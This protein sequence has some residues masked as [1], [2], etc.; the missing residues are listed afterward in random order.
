MLTKEESKF[1]LTIPSSTD[2]RNLQGVNNQNI[3]II[4]DLLNVNFTIRNGELIFNGSKNNF[5]K[6][7]IIIN[8]IIELLNSDY[9]PKKSD[10]RYIIQMVNHGEKPHLHKLLNKKVVITAKKKVITPKT[11]HQKEYVDAIDKFDITFGIGPAGTGKTYLAVAKAVNY[12]R[13]NII[14]KLVLVRPAVEAGEKIGFLPGDIKEKVNP[15]LRPLYDALYEMLTPSKVENLIS[16]NVIEI[17]PLAFMRGRSLNDSFIIMDEAQNSTPDQMKMLLTRMGFGSKIIVTGDIT[18]VDLP[19]KQESGLVNA[20]QK[21]SHIDDIAFIFFSR[22]DV[23]R[24][25]LVQKIIK[26]YKN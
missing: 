15:Y 16:K 7:K 26:A 23:V 11:L 21:L 24:H 4:K 12:L 10:V 6:V 2:L 1:T 13:D 8:E 17:I 5:D 20:E 3:K 18:Q 19:D 25:S 14:K 22:I 9:K